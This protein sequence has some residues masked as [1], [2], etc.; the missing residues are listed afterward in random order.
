MQNSMQGIRSIILR[1]KTTDL[2]KFEIWFHCETN[3]FLSQQRSDN[4][5]KSLGDAN[6]ILV[7][8]LIEF[9]CREYNTVLNV[10]TE[11]KKGKLRSQ[12][13][14]TKFHI[15]RLSIT[16]IKPLT[17]TVAFGSQEKEVY[18]QKKEENFPNRF[19]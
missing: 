12:F 3:A 11:L 6:R 19:P 13:T 2:K 14:H 5:R 9:S 15:Y 1:R 16:A 4:K 18:K 17:R 10:L 7:N 8:Q